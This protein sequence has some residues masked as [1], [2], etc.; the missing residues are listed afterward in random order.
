MKTLIR[1]NYHFDKGAYLVTESPLIL[2]CHHYNTFLQATIEDTKEYIDVY[3]ILIHSAAEIV[4]PHLRRF[5]SENS[6]QTPDEKKLIIADFFQFCGYG[7]LDLSAL[8]SDGGMV[9]APFEHYSWG[10]RNKFGMRN[11]HEPPVSFFAAGFLTA[12]ASA[13]FEEDLGVY[14]VIQEKCFTKGDKEIT[15]KVNKLLKK[16]AIKPLEH[17]R[18]FQN[19]QISNRKNTNIDS[20]AILAALDKMTLAG[21]ARTGLIDAFGV[22]LTRMY[23]DYYCM[24][25]YKMLHE[26]RRLMGDAG[27]EL[28]GDLL[29]EAG[30]VCSFNTLGGIMLSAEWAGLVQPMIQNREDWV[31]G[32]VAV[33]N[34]LGWGFWEIEE[35]LPGEKLVMKIISGY[36]SNFY[37]SVYTKSNFPISF[38]ARGGCEG[39]MNLIYLAEIQYGDTLDEEFY[40]SI[41][42]NPERFICRQTECRAMGAEYDKFEVKR[43]ST[44]SS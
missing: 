44:F 34:A 2:H 12:A 31:H 40:R 23:A 4:Y 35:V 1:G 14:D 16:A 25:S 33:I 37:Q 28:A 24:I 36:E 10:W 39:I 43:L 8:N 38:L 41:A 20:L 9:T 19:Y 21:S 26:L 6:V 32:I 3:P 42:N 7:L 29:T 15:F 27:V 5:F 13:I 30:H 22:L 11:E 17:E 18:I